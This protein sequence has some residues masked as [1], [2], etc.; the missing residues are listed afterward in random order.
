MSGGKPLQEREW[1]VKLADMARTFEFVLHCVRCITEAVSPNQ[2][3]L[4]LLL[5]LSEVWVL[6]FA[7]I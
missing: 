2:I 1:L 5:L 7:E 3:I 4:L 6:D